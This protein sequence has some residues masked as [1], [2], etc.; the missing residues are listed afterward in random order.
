MYLLLD[1]DTHLYVPKCDS[2]T[3]TEAGTWP[4]LYQSCC[5]WSSLHSRNYFHVPRISNFQRHSNLTDISSREF[6]YFVSLLSNV[7]DDQVSSWLLENIVLTRFVS[8]ITTW[9]TLTCK[10]TSGVCRLFIKSHEI[11]IESIEQLQSIDP[12]LTDS[13]CALCLLRCVSMLEYDDG[14]SVIADIV[15]TSKLQMSDL[16]HI[17]EFSRSTSVSVGC[18][19]FQVAFSLIEHWDSQVMITQ[20][21]SCAK[22]TVIYHCIVIVMTSKICQTASWMSLWR[23]FITALGNTGQR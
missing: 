15:L 10:R 17:R 6:E 9:F 16:P 2:A 18:R 20:W 21:K 7:T 4:F 5:R 23:V 13:C 11:C 19:H 8:M 1:V 14:M 3:E 22:F 12:R